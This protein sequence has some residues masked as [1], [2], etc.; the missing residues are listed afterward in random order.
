MGKSTISMVMFNSY[1]TNYQNLFP[2][3]TPFWLVNSHWNNN[4]IHGRSPWCPRG[5]LIITPSSH[6][7]IPSA[8]PGLQSSGDCTSTPHGWRGAGHRRSRPAANIRAPGMKRRKRSRRGDFGDFMPG[9]FHGDFMVISWSNQ[10]KWSVN[11]GFSGVQPLKME[12]SWEIHEIYLEY[13]VPVG[14]RKDFSSKSMVWAMGFVTIGLVT[15][16]FHPFVSKLKFSNWKSYSNARVQ[17]FWWEIHGGF[18]IAMF[19]YWRVTDNF[20]VRLF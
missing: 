4:K 7:G 11:G 6:L 19:D 14:I 16:L 17:W 18:S 1:V 8:R 12:V 13:R 10:E 9:D 20:I 3:H 15:G 5:P 2:I